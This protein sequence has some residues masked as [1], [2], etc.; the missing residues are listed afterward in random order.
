MSITNRKLKKDVLEYS[1]NVKCKINEW[2]HSQGG[3][4]VMEY[5]YRYARFYLWIQLLHGHLRQVNFGK[6]YQQVL[7]YVKFTFYTNLV[8]YK[9]IRQ[10]KNL[11]QLYLE[12]L[13]RN[14]LLITCINCWKQISS[15][16]TFIYSSLSKVS[17]EN[18]IWKLLLETGRKDFPAFCKFGSL[19]LSD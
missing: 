8:D 13:N 3:S 6:Q 1:L 2:H 17:L 10:D 19:L 14:F 18:V 9:Q 12:L 15:W 5:G 16:H 11:L 7:N 4:S